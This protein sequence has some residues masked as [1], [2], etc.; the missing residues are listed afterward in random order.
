MT[1]SCGDQN[2]TT[3]LNTLS[4]EYGPQ[5]EFIDNNPL[6]DCQSYVFSITASKYAT[7]KSA[8]PTWNVFDVRQ[9]LRQTCTYYAAGWNEYVG[10]GFPQVT[11]NP[12]G[13]F[14]PANLPT[15]ATNLDAGPP[16]Q[17]YAQ[18]LSCGSQILF[19][20]YNFHQTAFASTVIQAN[21]V[22]IYDGDGTSFVWT[23]N[24]PWTTN[25]QFF[26]K[27]LDGRL[28]RS[29]I[30]TTIS[31][32]AV[33]V[34]VEVT[35]YRNSPI[36]INVLANDRP[37]IAGAS[38]S[39]VSITALSNPDAGTISINADQTIHF[40]PTHT[41]GVNIAQATVTVNVFPTLGNTPPTISPISNQQFIQGSTSNIPFTVNDT[42]TPPENLA[43]SLTWSSPDLFCQILGTGSSRTLQI[44]GNIPVNG[45]AVTLTYTDWD[46]A[47]NS[48]SFQVTVLTNPTLPVLSVAPNSSSTSGNAFTYNI[49]GDANTS[50]TVYSSTDLTNWTA[51]GNMTLNASGAGLFTDNNVNGVG[52]MA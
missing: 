23:P 38:L 40:I 5:L 52:P 36:D 48:V 6:C 30:Y 19:T 17:P 10:Y 49:N 43:Q 37:G 26:T 4:N 47:S 29:E 7:L 16:I 18:F 14:A 11:N 39:L 20:W 46:L 33:A 44:T 42:Y 31:I 8:H 28:S 35:T 27:L 12:G 51:V 25:I 41:D 21:G 24:I 22:T 1:V 2:T 32:A 15:D 3:N 34:P 45:A 50:W 9:A 13:N